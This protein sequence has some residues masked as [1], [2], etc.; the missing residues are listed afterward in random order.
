MDSAL[1]VQA[2]SPTARCQASLYTIAI[3]PH[4]LRTHQPFAVQAHRVSLRASLQVPIQPIHYPIGS[5]LHP[6]VTMMM[7]H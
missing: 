4:H 2:T 3:P 7:S 6:G 5:I 1:R